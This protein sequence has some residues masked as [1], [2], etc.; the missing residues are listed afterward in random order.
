MRKASRS[1]CLFLIVAAA[2]LAQ[3]RGG[4]TV[5][6][7]STKLIKAGRVLDVR[8]GKYLPD[9][10]ILTDG[11][12]IKEIGPWSEVQ[13][14]APKD[15]TMID[16]GRATLLPGLIDCHAHLLIAAELGRMDAWDLVINTISRMSPSLRQLM[17]ARNAREVLE[18][19]VT[20]AR[21]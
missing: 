19:G 17:G 9:E 18:A 10:G 14:R 15:A 2:L 11:E 7:S 20:S 21:V 8:N 4:Q 6:T 3:T 16:L 1:M 5:A 12:R 13:S